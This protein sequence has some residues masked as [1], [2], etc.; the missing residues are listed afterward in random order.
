LAEEESAAAFI[1]SSED[2][3]VLLQFFISAML[4]LLL[5]LAVLDGRLGFPFPFFAAAFREEVGRSSSDGEELSESDFR[6]ER[7]SNASY[8]L[9]DGINT[10]DVL[11]KG[12]EGE[13]VGEEFVGV[14]EEEDGQE[15]ASSG[16]R[17]MQIAGAMI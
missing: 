16:S 4:L 10:A 9:T 17:L 15:V 13:A 1:V 12:G 5:F 14:D 7:T 11:V 3:R 2:E 8:S 6:Q